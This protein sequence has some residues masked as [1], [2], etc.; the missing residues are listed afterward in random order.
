MIDRREFVQSM[1][2]LGAATSLRPAA[3]L[4]AA[5]NQ[6]LK[7]LADAALSTARQ[8]GASYADIRI[9]RYRN[10]FIFTRDRRVQNI[11][12]TEDFGFGVRVIVDGTWGFASSSRVTRDDVAA[13]ARQAV[14]IARANKSINT[15]PVRQAPVEAYPDAEWNTPVKKDPFELALQPKI[16]L[17]LQINEEALKVPGASFVSAFML[18]VNEKKFFASSEGSYITQSLIRSYPNFSVTSVDRE[19][20]RFYQ[21]TSLPAPMGMGYEYI[22]SLPLLEEARVAAQEAVAMHKAKPAV[23]G[24][25]TLILHPTNLWLTIHE[26]VGHPTELDRALG[27]EANFAGTSFL[28]PDKLGKFQFGS[29]LC[30]ILG[31]KT[32]DKAMATCGY[33]DDGVKTTSFPIIKDGT[34]VDYQTTRDQAHLIGQKASHGCSYADNWS[35]VPFQRMPNVSL[36]PNEKDVSEQDIIAAT[37]DGLFVKGDSS[38]SIDHQRYNFQFSGQTFW[39]VKNG[40][41]TTQLR[42]VA[43]QSNTPEFWKSLDML[44]GKSTYQLGGAFGDGKGQPVQSNSVSHGCPVARFAKVN[45]LN[46]AR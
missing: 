42:D 43:Y 8:A 41:I 3:A 9:N 27:Y 26:S 32:Q 16:D 5:P 19:T 21:R 1:I 31:D 38:Y 45:V 29:P 12:N 17:L 28:T 44:G 22:E 10:Q 6:E 37:D 39:E 11:V 40:K 33:D 14:G 25:K 18:F 34:F 24:Q 20:N 46:T 2:A 23:A 36:Q 35:S 30:T 13:I 15:D 7:T 4:F